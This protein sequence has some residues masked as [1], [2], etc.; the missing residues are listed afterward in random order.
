MDFQTHHNWTS[1]VIHLWWR[2]DILSYCK[3]FSG[4][5]CA[6]PIAFQDIWQ[7]KNL[8][9]FRIY[10]PF[11]NFLCIESLIIQIFF[12]SLS[13]T[14]KKLMQ[15]V[16]HYFFLMFLPELVNI[17]L[18]SM[19][20]KNLKIIDVSFDEWVIYCHHS[21]SDYPKNFLPSFHETIEVWP[22]VVS[23]F[24]KRKVV[25]YFMYRSLYQQEPKGQQA[26][27]LLIRSSIHSM[28]INFKE[29]VSVAM[30]RNLCLLFMHQSY[31][32]R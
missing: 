31:V 24:S 30:C 20:W 7:K 26:P 18:F 23:K 17:K 27:C 25:A 21:F 9:N 11:C 6:Y 10:V 16:L 13:S 8:S 29:K 4:A 22:E 32:M 15:Q 14:S 5:W 3:Y 1:F 28:P 12:K 2:L 19:H